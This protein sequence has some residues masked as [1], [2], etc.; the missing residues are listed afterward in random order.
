MTYRWAATIALCWFCQLAV[1]ASPADD[2]SQ[3]HAAGVE[4]PKT[5]P[6]GTP[7]SIIDVLTRISDNTEA[8]VRTRL[9][10]AQ[11]KEIYLLMRVEVMSSIMIRS[12]EM[13]SRPALDAKALEASLNE[14][15]RDAQ[16]AS[17][18]VGGLLHGDSSLA[19]EKVEDP[20]ALG[21]LK[22]LHC[23]IALLGEDIGKLPNTFD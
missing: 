15:A 17:K 14:L 11:G 3:S 23:E 13:I 6:I 12:A 7:A 16:F 19:I 21:K 1:S 4:C 22:S 10:H 18:I 20:E 9:E 2:G 5:S 8:V